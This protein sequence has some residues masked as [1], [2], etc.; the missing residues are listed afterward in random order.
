MRHSSGAVASDVKKKD[1]EI[2]EEGSVR[3]SARERRPKIMDVI[4]SVV[5]AAVANE[6]PREAAVGRR[7]QIWWADEKVFYAGALQSSQ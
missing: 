7:L 5:N 3:S 2:K 4:P 6:A 1:E